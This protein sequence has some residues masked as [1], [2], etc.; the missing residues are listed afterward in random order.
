MTAFAQA[1]DIAALASIEFL[2]S[3][4]GEV[5]DVTRAPMHS[6]GFS[7]TRFERLRVVMADGYTRSLVLKHIDPRQDLT[8]RRSGGVSGREAR[9]L[10]E[11]ALDPI[12]DVFEAPYL[13]YAV[14]GDVSAVLM[15]DLAEHLLPDVREPLAAHQEE[16]LVRRLAMMH[17]R[18]WESSARAL[19]WLARAEFVYGFLA[20]GEL[21]VEETRGPL[22]TVMVAARQGWTLAQRMLPPAVTRLVTSP[23]ADLSG[24]TAGLPRSILHGDTKVANFALLPHGRVAAFDWAIVCEGCP[25]I[26][27]G[28][29]VAVNASRLTRS[30]EAVFGLYRSALQEHLGRTLTDAMWGR[31]YDAAVLGG[32]MV[33]LWNKALNVQKGVAGASEEWDWWVAQLERLA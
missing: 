16:A 26:D 2:T 23:P 9:V 33:L 31:M 21:A 3:V 8:V 12:W 20:P 6:I 24:V 15:H 13:A 1:T 10:G 28:W 17:A 22:P 18:F 19:P 14:E 30:K 7:G 5:R 4:V 25:T 11:R 29:Y 32:A 27:I